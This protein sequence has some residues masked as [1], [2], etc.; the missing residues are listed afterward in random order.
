MTIVFRKAGSVV[1]GK[2]GEAASKAM[3]PAAAAAAA[4]TSVESEA[5]IPVR[6]P[7]AV[8]AEEAPYMQPHATST[9]V[10]MM[11][12]RN[13]FQR[14]LQE[15]YPERYQ[16]FRKLF[17]FDPD[18]TYDL[19][20]APIPN[21]KVPISKTDPSITHMYRTPSP[22]SQAPVRPPL[23]EPDEDPFDSGYFKRDTRR[24]YLSSEL[25]NP[26]IEKL[27]LQLMNPDQNPA[28][29]EELEHVQAGPESS[30]GNKGRFAT[31]PT[32]FDPT[33]LR[34]TMSVTWP[35]LEASLDQHMPDHLP[36]PIWMG[37]EADVIAWYRE[38]DLPLPL[39]AYYTPLKVP[40]ERRVARW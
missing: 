32:Q 1:V 12:W 29:Q 25:G 7:R 16:Q 11:P 39:G 2:A 36:T 34:A 28:V 20:G 31:G 10:S 18:N 6:P 13:W 19:Q 23:W 26:T 9:T 35:A 8:T 17:F 3:S 21:V 24:R 38:R 30:P 4:V 40:R 5:K 15:N 14:W 33:G 37:K 27:K 22:G